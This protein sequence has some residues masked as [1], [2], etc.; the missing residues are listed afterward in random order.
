[1]THQA[2]TDCFRAV[3]EGLIFTEGIMCR[4]MKNPEAR[5][6][7]GLGDSKRDLQCHRL[8][9]G[10]SP[11]IDIQLLQDFLDMVFDGKGADMK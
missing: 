9:Y 5:V 10:M 8:G 1:M 6:L 4:A 11:I 2:G 7:C 3:P